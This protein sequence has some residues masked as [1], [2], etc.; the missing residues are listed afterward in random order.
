MAGK[1]L[2]E[3]EDPYFNDIDE[4]D[5][6]LQS[7]I[8][9]ALNL[10]IIHRAEDLK[11]RPLDPIKRIEALAFTVRTFEAYEEEIAL[12]EEPYFDDI[13]IVSE[14]NDQRWI[15]ETAQKG[16]EALLVSGYVV[17]ENRY[18]CPL[19]W[20]TME[21]AVILV[22][23]LISH[24]N[25][26]EVP[27][28]NWFR[29]N[30]GSPTATSWNVT[31]NNDVTGVREGTEYMASESANFEDSEW[32][33]YNSAPTFFINPVDGVK[34]IYFKVR[35]GANIESESDVAVDS[36]IIVLNEDRPIVT[37]FEINNGVESTTDRRVTLN[38][39]STGTP[40][41]Y[42]ASLNSQFMDAGWLTYN[43]AP[44]F[45]IQ[46]G[47][48]A[49]RIYFKVKNSAGIESNIVSDVIIISQSDSPFITRF[50]INN[51]AEITKDLTVR[52]NNTATRNPTEY[53][54]SEDPEFAGVEWGQYSHT[55]TFTLSE[56]NGIK[57]VFFKVRNNDGE[58]V[59]ASDKIMLD[60]DET[61]NV[62]WFLI[63][64]GA[65]I[66]NSRTV[67]LNNQTTGYP[68]HYKIS[69]DPNFKGSDWKNY[70]I[71]PRFRLSKS[72]GLKTLYFKVKRKNIESAPKTD[73]II[74]E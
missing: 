14:T 39:D 44:I 31:L 25:R 29:I 48:G 42:M 3:A 22:N 60:R 43:A 47:Y 52:L 51:G 37:R 64:N 54:A 50:K 9:K 4:L 72:K 61:P 5:R 13:Q 62:V 6:N 69:E 10:G 34:T 35:N 49:K 74:L 20:T 18:M 70:S 1:T 40:T 19:R 45:T 57:E 23:N 41:Q 46:K 68:T 36:I 73:I 2:Q 28:I 24:L 71:E 8:R 21:E 63:N 67:T 59:P 7:S 15:W 11:F 58:A 53:M 30:N 26:N 27:V 66:T 12:R 65:K 33:P 32:L 38:N 17:D 16:R 56:G 55:P